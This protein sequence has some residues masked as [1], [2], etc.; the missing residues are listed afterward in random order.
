[1]KRSNVLPFFRKS[2]WIFPALSLVTLV[3]GQICAKACAF[4]R[5]D[6]LGLDLNIFGILFYSILLVLSVLHL[7]VYQGD[8]L[9]KLLALLTSVGM[10]AE[11]IL[12]KFQVQNDVYCPKCLISG[13][14]LIVMFFVMAQNLR[15]WVVVLM[16]LLGAVFTSL[17]FSGSVIP[18]YADELSLPQF[19]NDKAPIEIVVYSDYLCPACR[20]AD[21]EIN[22]ELR[23]LSNKAKILFVDVP[24]HQGSLEYSEV[25]LYAWFETGNNLETAIKIRELLFDAGKTKS[26]Q[27]GLLGALKAKGIPFKA[28]TERA[29]NIFRT[30]YNPLMNEDKIRA[31]PTVVIVKGNDRQSYTGGKNILKAL[32]E[33][34]SSGGMR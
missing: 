21:V 20:K 15:K 32:E 12:V 25:F 18:S 30:L 11:L 17:T 26:G 7:K 19:G 16:V 13:F 22:A 6:I 29:K 33:I 31:T 23:R 24:I 1:M 8:V 4:I 28:D 3:I 34:I 2:V 10:G 27:A 9:M 5:G 14:F